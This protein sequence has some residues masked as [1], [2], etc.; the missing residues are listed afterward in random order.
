MQLETKKKTKLNE[1]TVKTS[2]D[3]IDHSLAHQFVGVVQ[4]K[5]RR[6]MISE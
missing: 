2:I 1:N 4:L 3:C 5:A 6:A